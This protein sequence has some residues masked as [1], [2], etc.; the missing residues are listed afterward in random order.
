MEQRICSVHCQERLG[1]VGRRELG[2]LDYSATVGQTILVQTHPSG[3]S[4][5]N[6][7]PSSLDLISQH[8]SNDAPNQNFL[9]RHF[10]PASLCDK[11]KRKVCINVYTISLKLFPGFFFPRLER[12]S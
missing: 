8:H 10:V 3:S 9:L 12:I 7:K 1:E 11:E 2:T 4:E 5:S 6:R